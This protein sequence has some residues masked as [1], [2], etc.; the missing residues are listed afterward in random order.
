MFGQL[1]AMFGQMDATFNQLDMF[2]QEPFFQG[3]TLG[4]AT[5]RGQAATRAIHQ[6]QQAAAQRQATAEQRTQAVQRQD[7][8]DQLQQVAAQLLGAAGQRQAATDQ[9]WDDAAR[10]RA[11]TSQSRRVIRQNNYMRMEIFSPE[12]RMVVSADNP[13]TITSQGSSQRVTGSLTVASS[14][15]DAAGKHEDAQCS[16]NYVDGGCQSARFPVADFCTN[17]NNP[18]RRCLAAMH[19]SELPPCRD[20]PVGEP[21]CSE[22]CAV[23]FE[24]L[25]EYPCSTTPCLHTVHKKCL[26]AWFEQSKTCP[27]CRMDLQG[28]SQQRPL[29]YRMSELKRLSCSDLKW[30][31][32]FLH[33]FV[34]P[35]TERPDLEL[36]IL[37]N[38]HVIMIS[39]VQEMTAMPTSSLQTLVHSGIGTHQAVDCDNSDLISFLFDSGRVVEDPN[40]LS[41]QQHREKERVQQQRINEAD[42]ASA[43]VNDVQL[44]SIM[45]RRLVPDTAILLEV[46]R[47]H[48]SLRRA[49]LEGPELAEIRVALQ[50]KGNEVELASC[51]A[52]VFVRPEQYA[53]VL[54]ALETVKLQPRH[55]ITTPEFEAIVTSVIQGVSRTAV[56]NSQSI[57][58]S[59]LYNEDPD[60]P[61][62]IKRTF[63][64]LP[65]P[66][67]LTTS[68]DR[69]V[70]FP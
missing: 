59:P 46:T 69:A 19:R 55:V 25:G 37:G 5:L 56:K 67:S 49:L 1:N 61:V 12:G 68:S 7:T 20:M 3:E 22:T 64:T 24:A 10:S 42:A 27:L 31:A 14:F 16:Q 34:A 33:I 18:T 65:V 50:E 23:C 48:Q 40:W 21:V 28:P 15:T 41:D 35:G 60:V 52:K 70:T 62:E 29:R 51:G 30:I 58:T 8:V 54:V 4:A 11:E 9:G 39:H 57:V 32:K 43:A 63:I 38:R 13:T 53:N 17:T 2:F 26:S 47:T 66:N 6:R 36:A 45:K 44:R